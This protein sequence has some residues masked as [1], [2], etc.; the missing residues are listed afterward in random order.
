MA[1]HESGTAA[2]AVKHI[3][4][5]IAAREFDLAIEQA[6]EV[7]KVVPGDARTRFL[8]GMAQRRK[9]DLRGA[10]A[11]LEAVVKDADEVGGVHQELGYVYY[12]LSN[13]NLA[14][15]ELRRAV[16]LQEEL[17]EAWRLL[18]QLLAV[19]EHEEEAE[20]AWRQYLALTNRHPAVIEA[21]RLVGE[22]KL[23]MAEGICKEYLKRFPT[24][25]TVIRLLAEIALQLEVHEDAKHL[26]ERCL[27]LAPDF[28]LARNNYANALGKLQQYDE[29]LAEIATLE[30][31]EP[32]N[33]SHSILAASI[34]VRTGDYQQAID[35]YENILKRVPNHALLQ[36]SYGHALKTVGRQED[37]I[38]AYRAS[39]ESSASLGEAYWSLANLKT[40]RFDDHEIDTMKRVVESDER[41]PRDYFHLCFSLGK[42]LED[43]GEY[44]EA[45]GFYD[46]GNTFKREHS[47]YDADD[48]TRRVDRIIETFTP[49]CFEARSAMGCDAPDPIFIV[50]LP[51]SGSTLLEQILASHSQVDGT[52]ELPNIPMTARRLGDRKTKSGEA[53]LYP[54]SLLQLDADELRA[55]GEEYIEKTRIQ[56]AGAPFFIDKMP[57]NFMHVGLIRLI[58]PNARIIDAR[59]HP[60]AT[61][62]S[63]FKQLFAAGQEFTYGLDNVGRYYA[64]YIRLM[65]HWDEVLPGHVLLVQYEDVV[66]NFEHEVRRILDYCELEFESACLDFYKT[67]RAVRTAS[68]EQ[69]RQPLYRDSVEQWRFFEK[70]LDPLKSALGGVMERFPG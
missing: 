60:L 67:P 44:D 18:G 47:G 17:P 11:T 46:R 29:A 53:P 51:R 10:K 43:R 9:G 64:D 31:V 27:E 34:L 63:A 28:H 22:G 6:D 40:F 62:F 65:D 32:H 57:N 2:Q 12:G 5:M 37:A 7:L 61:C 35:R 50:G 41:A 56:R 3:Q 52:M 19:E 39:I 59:R 25:V 30:K 66:E 36:M 42:A 33:L 16:E 69:V 49:E 1:S 8:K 55:L 48:N 68:S 21:V 14:I 15:R 13:I 54:N 58:L 4:E 20:A 26:L 70:H 23:G 38:A 45:F 24:D